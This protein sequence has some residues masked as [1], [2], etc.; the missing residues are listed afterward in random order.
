ML[1]SKLPPF[2]SLLFIGDDY[3]PNSS[4]QKRNKMKIAYWWDEFIR[5]LRSFLL[6]LAH[7]DQICSETSCP[8]FGF[9]STFPKKRWSKSTLRFFDVVY[10]TWAKK[11]NKS[12]ME[13]DVGKKKR[14]SKEEFVQFLQLPTF[15][16]LPGTLFVSHFFFKATKNP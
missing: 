1:E 3:K 6:I 14:I 7:M 10:R 11:P 15:L 4:S 13:E 8:F 9:F 2:G 16:L 5:N 12:S